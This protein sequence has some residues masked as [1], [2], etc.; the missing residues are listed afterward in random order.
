MFLCVS[1]TYKGAS[2]W[3]WAPCPPGEPLCCLLHTQAVAILLLLYCVRTAG[4]CM[5]TVGTCMSIAVVLGT[6]LQVPGSA[7][8]STVDPALLHCHTRPAHA[9]GLRP[10]L[11]LE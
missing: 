4:T 8:L 2:L 11:L 5:C 10:V 3:G 1:C 9:A 7:P 6:L